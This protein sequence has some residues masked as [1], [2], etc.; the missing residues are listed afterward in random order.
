MVSRHGRLRRGGIA[1]GKGAGSSHT[2]TT[3]SGSNNPTSRPVIMGWLGRG[4]AVG[5]VGVLAVV[6]LLMAAAPCMAAAQGRAALPV[7]L[8][9]SILVGGGTPC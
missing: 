5:A 9:P 2:T 3:N 4:G 1:G 7:E 6:S 8:N